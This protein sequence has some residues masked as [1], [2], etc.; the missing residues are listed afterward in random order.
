M[1]TNPTFA[2]P[3][4]QREDPL[5]HLSSSSIV[6]YRKGQII[7]SADQPSTN[8]YL[9]IEG[10]VQVPAHV[11]RRPANRHGHLPPR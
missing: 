7:F 10:K 6:E 8:M 11:P 3:S 4:K 1:A 9:V 5:L 2:A